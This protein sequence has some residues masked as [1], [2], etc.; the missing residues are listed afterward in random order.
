MRL[1]ASARL[2][3]GGGCETGDW[4]VLADLGNAQVFLYWP[5]GLKY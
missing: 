5:R 4:R 3:T 1:E 2:E